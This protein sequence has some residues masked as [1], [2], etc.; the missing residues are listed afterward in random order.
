MNGQQCYSIGETALKLG[1]SVVTIRRWDKLGKLPSQFRTIGNHRRFTAKTIASIH[2]DKARINV[3]YARVS[4]HDQKKDLETQA[5]YLSHYCLWSDW[6]GVKSC[7][8]QL[9]TSEGVLREELG[10]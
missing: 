2:Q 4:S 9:L 3:C 7:L 5:N 8:T 10:R 6:N 1:V